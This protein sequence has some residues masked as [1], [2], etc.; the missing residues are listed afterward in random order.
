MPENQ[1]AWNSN[2]Q[3]IKETNRTTRLV[4]QPIKR[5]CGKAGDCVGW[6]GW[7]KPQQGCGLCRQGWLNG[8]LG[9]RADCGLG[10]G[11]CG[12][13]NSQSH[14]SSLESR[15][16]TSRWAALFPLCPQ[17]HRQPHWAG[18]GGLPCPGEYLG[19]R[20]LTTY[21]LCQDKEIWPKWKNRARLQKES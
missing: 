18:T 15:L 3:G 4:T 2:N 10:R 1:T 21:Q 16:E 12:G 20:P 19:P 9:F 11:C 8:K 5:T 7:E 13:R 6:A 17:P 14:Q